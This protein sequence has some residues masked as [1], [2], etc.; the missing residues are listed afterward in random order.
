MTDTREPTKDEID[1]MRSAL[2]AAVDEDGGPENFLSK[3]IDRV[4]TEDKYLRRFLMHKHNDEKVAVKQAM[5]ALVWR[6]ENNPYAVTKESVDESFFDTGA[7]Y[8]HNRD[9]DGCKIL[10]FEVQKHAKGTL[11]MDMLKKFLIYWLERLD[12]E[13][14]GEKVTVFFDMRNTGMKNM[15]M[16]FI[17]YMIGVFDS[18]Y[19]YFLNYIIVFKMAWILNAIWKIIKNLLPADAQH[20]IKF[21]DEK[22]LSQYVAADQ[23]LKVWSG[24]D[25]YTYSFEPEVI[26]TP[27]LPPQTLDIKDDGDYKKVTFASSGVSPASTPESN[28]PSIVRTTSGG[29]SLDIQPGEELMFS[30]CSVGA[31]ASISISNPSETTVAF[32]IKTTSPEKYRVR[33]SLGILESGRHQEISVSLNDNCSATQLVRDKFLIMAVHANSD[34]LNSQEVSQLFR[35]G[36]KED[37]FEVRLRVGVA[38]TENT[39]QNVSVNSTPVKPQPSNSELMSK[40]DQMLQRQTALD[41]QLR[42]ARRMA[43]GT[44]L[45]MIVIMCFLMVASNTMTSSV[46]Q[47]VATIQKQG[48]GSGLGPDGTT[49]PL[50][51]PHNTEL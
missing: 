38:A 19:P 5:G 12:R 40:L 20:I 11:N 21:V 36:S 2:L 18:Y 45:V 49:T 31:A 7:L 47:Y 16:E 27:P 28:K 1:S 24:Q 26:S 15:D 29:L 17:Q 8:V 39:T 23:S 42:S 4:K 51:S 48:Q 9:V 37:V 32:K 25:D 14:K 13:E 22:N 34:N 30:T 3:D 35:S 33:P 44:L 46:L 41:E 50:H 43:Y 10:I 6:K